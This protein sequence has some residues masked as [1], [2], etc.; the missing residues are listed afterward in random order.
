MERR[1]LR[2]R[3]ISRLRQID[4]H[5]HDVAGVKPRDTSREA[6]EASDEQTGAHQEDQRQRHFRH[7]ENLAQP[8]GLPCRVRRS[9]RAAYRGR[10]W[11]SGRWAQGRPSTRSAATRP[12]R[13]RKHPAVHLD[14]D[15]RRQ[16][17]AAARAPAGPARATSASAAPA[18]PANQGQQGGLRQ[19]LPHQTSAA[20]AQ[21]ES[22]RNLL[23]PRHRAHEQQIR[24]IRA[25]NQQDEHDGAAEDPKRLP[26][27]A[28]HRLVQRVTRAMRSGSRLGS[29][30]R[31][32]DPRSRSAC[33]CSRVTPGFEPADYGPCV[34]E[35]RT[36]GEPSAASR[37]PRRPG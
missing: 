15:V 3:R 36:E 10:R 29:G 18:D 33:A 23:T 11:P 1:D 7:D 31:L 5:R 6:H 12:D 27:A 13:E 21:R 37:T 28:H 35:V 19:Q 32:G 17:A 25:R 34:A 4:R 2:G 26:D 20:G 16:T 22:R 24:H 8:A 14:G 30:G 9:P